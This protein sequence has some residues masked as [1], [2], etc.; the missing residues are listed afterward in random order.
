MQI[1]SKFT[2]YATN[3]DLTQTLKSS[4]QKTALNINCVK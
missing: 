2:Q 3:A 1:T 4:I